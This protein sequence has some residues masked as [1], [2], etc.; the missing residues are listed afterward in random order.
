MVS[1]NQENIFSEAV[2]CDIGDKLI[3]NISKCS[4][5]KALSYEEF[6][7]FE[8]KKLTIKNP[9]INNK[10]ISSIHSLLNMIKN[11]ISIL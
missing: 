2:F 7:R 11:M 5:L 9:D 8:H 1:D 4:Q 3:E 6:D 10:K